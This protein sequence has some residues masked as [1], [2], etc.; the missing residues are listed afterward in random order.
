MVTSSSNPQMKRIVQLN[1]KAKT[2]YD[3]RVFVAEGIKMCQEAPKEQIVAVY[4]SEH[5]LAEPKNQEFLEDY[6][7]EVVSDKVFA[8]VSDTK[9]PQG[10]LCLV[11]M[12]QY[13]LEKLLGDFNISKDGDQPMANCP[14]L[15]ILEGIQ[16]PGNLGTMIR[17]AE[18]AGVTG[19]IMSKTTVDI[20]NPKVV[21]STMGSLFRV[22]FYL[23]DDLAKTIGTLKKQGITMYAAHLKGKL[24]YDQPNYCSACGFMIGN[25][26]NGDRKSVV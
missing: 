7:Y 6:P 4:V 16:D 9:T 3:Q 21:R 18:G 12:P 15:L 22:P 24:S 13:S 20:F 8:A 17:T 5:F 11:K 1:K 14:H 26:G 10:I 19:I 2:R 23:T 25:E